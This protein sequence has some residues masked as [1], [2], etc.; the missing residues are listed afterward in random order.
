M[1]K[2]I[3]FLILYILSPLALYCQ[4]TLHEDDIVSRDTI[5]YYNTDNTLTGTNNYGETSPGK[6]TWDFSD[7][8]NSG[9]DTLSF[10]F[11]DF[12]GSRESNLKITEQESETL[13]KKDS[14]GLYITGTGIARSSIENYQNMLDSNIAIPAHIY[15]K[16]PLPFLRFPADTNQAY[17]LSSETDTIR[18]AIKDTIQVDYDLCSNIYVDSLQIST[19]VSVT[20]EINDY[21]TLKLPSKNYEV[22]RQRLNISNEYNIM[23]KGNC[24]YLNEWIWLD[25]STFTEEPL[26]PD[27]NITMYRYWAGNMKYPVMDIAVDQNDEIQTLRYNADAATGIF[28]RQQNRAAIKVFPNPAKDHLNIKF[29]DN[30]YARYKVFIYNTKGKVHKVFTPV[31]KQTQLPLSHLPGGLLMVKITNKNGKVIYGKTVIK[32]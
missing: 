12:Q 9:T 20:S 1:K 5:I 10:D 7:L 32:R 3:P 16:S 15:L 6:S 8:N 29:T 30:H 24:A 22:L 11:N 27:E 23:I 18:V 13:Y 17:A 4:I 26:L 21:G 28:G 19:T 31:N 2:I 14:S 25:P